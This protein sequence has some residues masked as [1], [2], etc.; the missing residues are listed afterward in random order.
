MAS[1]GFALWL[2][3]LLFDVSLFPML[4]SFYFLFK[5]EEGLLHS[6]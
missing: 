4:L 3:S 5:G 2:A 6:L 1:G